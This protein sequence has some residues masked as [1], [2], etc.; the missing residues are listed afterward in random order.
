MRW[1]APLCVVACVLSACSDDGLGADCDLGGAD[2]GGCQPDLVCAA[3]EGGSGVCQIPYGGECDLEAD[4]SHCQG[5]SECV[6]RTEVDAEGM[7]TVVGRCYAGLHAPCDPTE[8]VQCEPELQCAPLADDTHQCELPV[9]FRGTVT[10]STTGAAI[11]GAHVIGVDETPTA[12]TD[13]AISEAD[14]SYQ[15][16]LPVIR[17]ADGTPMLGD[18]TYTLRASAD[19][20]L[21]FP[22][23]IRQ[24]LPVDS[25]LA[26]MTPEEGWFIE[27]TI[28]D[29]RLV[30][31][32]DPAAPRVSISGRVV[33]DPDERLPEEAGVLVVA[34][35][36][37]GDAL[38]RSALSSISGE[39]TIFN[40]PPGD[41]E[42]RGY[43]SGLQLTPQ[44]VTTAD[45]DL[46]DVDLL[47]NENALSSIS[48]TMQIVGSGDCD[49]SSIVLAVESTFDEAV[50]RGELPATLRAPPLPEP[51]N[52]E[53]GAS[54]TIDEI[55]DGRYVVLAGFE[56]DD[57]V[58]DPSDIGGTAIV[59]VE[60][61]ADAG[62]LDATFKVTSA[63]P[64]ISPGAT[65]PEEV[66]APLTLQWG[67][68]S[69]DATAVVE[70]FDAYGDNVFTMM[71]D[72]TTMSTE[73][74][75]YTG[76]LDSGMFYQFRVTTLGTGGTPL[77]RTED[78]RGVFFVP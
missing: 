31:V 2:N 11:E 32:A 14:G 25:G 28:A 27:G 67:G 41:Y 74:L 13:V 30:P 26:E 69:G 50:G 76:P 46:V 18:D 4:E 57:C 56:N 78:L 38:A 3:D 72:A 7:E 44:S 6:E 19:G 21:T 36:S 48:G 61:P 55:P 43:R 39:Y 71:P 1:I 35:P 17:N 60:L 68:T 73:S 34:N 49:M 64:T 53:A 37:S 63:I 22:S 9:A 54:W 33:V 59:H 42:V 52:L 47:A 65:D 62:A 29:I 66:S 45:A 8:E 75:G 16:N 10:D 12:V 51:P 15:L 77:Q 58:R 24:A 23:G 70:V 5:A 40:V 20:Y